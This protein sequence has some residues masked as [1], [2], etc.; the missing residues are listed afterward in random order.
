M[1]DECSKSQAILTATKKMELEQKEQLTQNEKENKAIAENSPSVPLTKISKELEEVAE[2]ARE[3]QSEN[4]EW[5][6]IKW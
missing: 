4:S 2:L 1:F 3:I 6:T 5:E